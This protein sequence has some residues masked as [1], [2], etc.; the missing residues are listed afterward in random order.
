L[1][2]Q[3]K[4]YFVQSQKLELSTLGLNL[5][6]EIM[7]EMN[8]LITKQ[9]TTVQRKISISFRDLALRGLFETSLFS[10][11]ELM[12]RKKKTKFNF[13]RIKTK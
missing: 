4:K 8:T 1:P 6:N 13:F 7:F 3:I 12:R 5:L 11:K 9:N 10:L 2:E